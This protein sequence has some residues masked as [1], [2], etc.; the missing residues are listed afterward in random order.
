MIGRVVAMLGQ[1]KGDWKFNWN[2]GA[3]DGKVDCRDIVSRTRLNE[4]WRVDRKGAGEVDRKDR[5]R[6]DRKAG[7]EIEREMEK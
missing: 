7:G 3:A 1:V 6:V 2:F 4:R 5:R